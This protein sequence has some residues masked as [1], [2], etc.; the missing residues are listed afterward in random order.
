M[1]FR[2]KIQKFQV[3][4]LLISLCNYMF[5]MIQCIKKNYFYGRRPSHFKKGLKD[6]KKEPNKT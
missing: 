5:R 6:G 2:A 4:K 3:I 1:K